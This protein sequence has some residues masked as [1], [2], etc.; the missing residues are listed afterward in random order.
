MVT[1]KENLTFIEHFVPRSVLGA[2]SWI[3]SFP[4][5]NTLSEVGT[6]AS[7]YFTDDETKS[8]RELVTCPGS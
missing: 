3:N 5:H 2:F 7:P 6:I 1:R 8:Q 4:L